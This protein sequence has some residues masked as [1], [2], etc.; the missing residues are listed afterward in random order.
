[1]L[2][3]KQLLEFIKDKKNQSFLNDAPFIIAG[4]FNAA[5]WEE[6][7]KLMTRDGILKDMTCSLPGTFHDYGRCVPN[8]KIDY[9]FGDGKI[10]F[11]SSSLW[12]DEANGVY[13]SDHY[14]VA[15]TFSIADENT[16]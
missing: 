14:P 7:V 4:D 3:A 10:N 2:G 11:I 8:T 13:L 6:A 12:T 16:I 1:M 9:I 5:P 15:V